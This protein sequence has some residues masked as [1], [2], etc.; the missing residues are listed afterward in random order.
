M[1]SIDTL[2]TTTMYKKIKN[3]FNQV[4][5]SH[6]LSLIAVILYNVI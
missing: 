2:Y 5:L 6:F 3:Q 1:R 4:F